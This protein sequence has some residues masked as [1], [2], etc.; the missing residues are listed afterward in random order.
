M[1]FKRLQ[2]HLDIQIK[3]SQGPTAKIETEKRTEIFLAEVQATL[4]GTLM[5]SLSNSPTSVGECVRTNLAHFSL[6]CSSVAV[7]VM[8]LTA[9]HHFF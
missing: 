6:S 3:V 4:T 5:A 9:G 8:E 1:R 2:S 7:C